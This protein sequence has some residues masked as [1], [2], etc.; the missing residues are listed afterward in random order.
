VRS[1]SQREGV[2]DAFLGHERRIVEQTA[3]HPACAETTR[4]QQEP[5]QWTDREQPQRD[6][7]LASKAGAVTRARLATRSG[8]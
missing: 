4:P 1:L 7:D 2:L 6:R 3:L 5:A 8:A